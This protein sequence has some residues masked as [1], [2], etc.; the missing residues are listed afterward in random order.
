MKDF[1]KIEIRY[2][3]A[4][5]KRYNDDYHRSLIMKAHDEEF[6]GFVAKHYSRGDRVLDLGCGPASLWH[7]WKKYLPEPALLI[8]VDISD[9]MIDECKRLFPG[10]DFRLGS[11]FRIPADSGSIDLIIISSALHHIPDANLPEVFKEIHRVLDE[12]G[13]IAGREPLSKQRFGDEPGWL[14]G[15][16]M[17]FRHLVYRLTRT[18][19]YPEPKIGDHHHAYIPNE[20]IETLRKFVS[21][22]SLQ[23]KYPVSSYI[24]RCDHPLVT[25]IASIL[26]ASIGHRGG[27][28]IFYSAIKNYCDANAVAFCVKQEL[29]T[30]SSYCYNKKEFLALLQKAAEILE[31]EIKDS[32]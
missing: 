16:L 15:A 17:S 29:K 20:F 25:K 3:N 8:G 6:A 19:E 21:P 2:E 23:F 10:D 32:K 28:E 12:H 18:R 13:T 31:R 26:D 9:G 4:I 14:S 5:A 7:L 24:L 22:K 1:E 27:H 11:A 30:D